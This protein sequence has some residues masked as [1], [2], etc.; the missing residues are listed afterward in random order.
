MGEMAEYWR[1][2]NAYYKAKRHAYKDINTQKLKDE[3][4]D[5]VSKNDGYHLI[6][7]TSK[8]KI[9]FYPSTGRFNG[10][11]EGQGVQI[12]LKRLIGIEYDNE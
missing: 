7:T 5:F 2:V 4:I 1:D 12:L 3:G 6:I 8:G 9:N 11:T 10:V